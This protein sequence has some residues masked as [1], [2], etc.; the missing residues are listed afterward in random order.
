MQTLQ[1]RKQMFSYFSCSSSQISVFVRNYFYFHKYLKLRI[2]FAFG[3]VSCYQSVPV[4]LKSCLQINFALYSSAFDVYWWLEAITAK[5]LSN[6]SSSG[7]DSRHVIK[8]L[9]TRIQ[10]VSCF[11]S[12]KKRPVVSL[13]SLPCCVQPSWGLRALRRTSFTPKITTKC[14][15]RVFNRV[16]QEIKSN[17][18]RNG[19]VRGWGQQKAL[20]SELIRHS[21]PEFYSRVDNFIH[22]SRPEKSRSRWS[23][24]RIVVCSCLRLNDERTFNTQ[25]TAASLCV[26]LQFNF[27]PINLLLC[28]E[29]GWDIRNVNFGQMQFKTKYFRRENVG[30]MKTVL[31]EALSE[32]RSVFLASS[33]GWEKFVWS[34][35]L[36]LPQFPFQTKVA[37]RQSYLC[38]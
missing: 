33:K 5:R 12:P 16:S 22:E 8:K 34:F 10:Q 17:H 13:R 1:K 9:F 3:S 27:L 23:G 15:S 14:I 21:V 18:Y 2:D 20:Q 26:R 4:S 36:R 31:S 37:E 29:R 11:S 7:D 19:S 28:T 30:Q 25:A 24:A 6:L 38:F 32:S 35:L